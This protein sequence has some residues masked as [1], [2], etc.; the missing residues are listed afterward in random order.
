MHI[1]F[2]CPSALEAYK[3][4]LDLLP[5]V[6]WTGKSIAAW[7][8]K[9]VEYGSIVNG[10]AAYALQ[11][12]YTD[13]ALEWLEMGWAIVWGQ[14]HN[15]HSPADILS[16]AH[17]HLAE[18]LSQVAVA[19][20][21]V[22]SRDIDLEDFKGLT[23]EEIA[24][25]HHC[26]AT[27]W[28]SL[29]E[30]VWALPGFE[31]F[32]EPKRLSS[33]KNV[34]KLGPV[35]LVNIAPMTCDALILC[36][37]QDNVLHILLKDFTYEDAKNLQE[38]LT[39]ALSAYE[40]NVFMN[41]LKKL[42]TCIVKPVLNGLAFLPCDS[43]NLPRLWW[44]PTGPLAFLPVHAARDYCTNEQGTK[45]SDYVISSYTPTLTILLDKLEKT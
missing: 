43:T 11:L 23:T 29:V 13:T 9:L 26:L 19:L 7:H 15:L 20:G 16:D 34:A 27:E 24:R 35:V 21:K 37:N 4:A 39:K 14:L 31:D 28:D 33:L 40:K 25:E 3:V 32:L 22:T 38:R 17:P 44:C 8:R 1:T 30:E 2:N 36:S 12:G 41:I 45:L 10:A 42:W 5:Q 18:R 6:A